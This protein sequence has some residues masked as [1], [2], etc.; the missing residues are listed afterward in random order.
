MS[1]PFETGLVIEDSEN[2]LSL[3][4]D[5]QMTSIVLKQKTPMSCPYDSTDESCYLRVD[6]T[7]MPESK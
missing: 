6:I 4:K 7:Q 1:Q 2:V 5:A 3:I